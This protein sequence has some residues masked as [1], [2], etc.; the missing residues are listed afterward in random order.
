MA[1]HGFFGR[2]LELLANV[3]FIVLCA[4]AYKQHIGLKSEDAGM[5]CIVFG[6]IFTLRLLLSIA[7]GGSSSVKSKAN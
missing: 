3:L 7:V 4:F 1:L 6:G 2:N 5:P